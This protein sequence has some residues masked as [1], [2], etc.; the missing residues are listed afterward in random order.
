MCANM[1]DCKKS[2]IVPD[3]NTCCKEKI[4]QKQSKMFSSNLTF[5]IV[6]N[7]AITVCVFILLSDS[8]GKIIFYFAIFA[9]NS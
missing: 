4:F 6:L 3:I 8:Y 1:Y 5:L 7:L 2:V 9:Q